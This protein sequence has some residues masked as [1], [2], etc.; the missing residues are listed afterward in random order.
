MAVKKR[1]R[2]CLCPDHGMDQPGVLDPKD[3]ISDVFDFGHIIDAFKLV[4]ERKSSTKKIVIR[5]Y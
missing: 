2:G 1:G 3:F 4:E 5:Y